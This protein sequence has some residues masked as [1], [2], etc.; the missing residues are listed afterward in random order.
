MEK[1]NK[2]RNQVFENRSIESKSPHKTVNTINID[3][4]I[5]MAE[6]IGLSF[7]GLI[8]EL[9]RRIGSILIAHHHNWEANFA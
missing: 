9:R 8:G 6:S 2:M 7:N 3:D 4:V 5:T 1:K